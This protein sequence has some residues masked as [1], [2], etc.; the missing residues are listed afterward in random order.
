[1]AVSRIPKDNNKNRE[2]SLNA[3]SLF[4]DTC[5]FSS[6][7]SCARNLG[8]SKSTISSQISSLENQIGF[9]LLR[10][11][12][13]K[14]ALTPEGREF[15]LAVKPAVEEL[16][17]LSMDRL[18]SEIPKRTIRATFPLDFPI[19]LISRIS[20]EF[21]E[22]Y[23]SVKFAISTTNEV[24]DF[25]DKSIDIAVRIGEPRGMDTVVKKL[26]NIPYLLCRSTDVKRSSVHGHVINPEG[27]A[28]IGFLNEMLIAD[29]TAKKSPLLS[30]SKGALIQTNSMQLATS[31]VQEGMGEAWLPNFMVQDRINSGE[32]SVVNQRKLLV[33]LSVQYPSRKSMDKQ[34]KKFGEIISDV[35]KRSD[36]VG[37]D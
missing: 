13:R 22:L 18:D 32:I 5:S 17:R 37:P 25:V 1:M 8:K 36:I 15:L 31:L 21:N 6:F 19:T 14:I 24:E 3:I 30:A 33:P 11:S 16:K 23:P 10:R 35:V 20:R 34:L 7:S 4:V 29:E 28:N 12:S 2:V 9:P 27:L 26:G